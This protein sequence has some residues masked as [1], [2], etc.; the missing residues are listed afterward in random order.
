MIA[1]MQLDEASLLA[2]EIF[3]A[4]EDG[5]LLANEDL[6]LVQAAL[7]FGIDNLRPESLE[8]LR[9][10]A[11]EVQTGAYHVERVRSLHGQTPVPC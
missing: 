4:T 9:F 11:K 1:C 2:T 6:M 10:L 5:E 8:R 7:D 3:N